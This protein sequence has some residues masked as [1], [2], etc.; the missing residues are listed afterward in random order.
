MN[1]RNASPI[2]RLRDFAIG[3]TIQL[4]DDKRSLVISEMLADGYYHLTNR[5]YLSVTAHGC[6]E[7]MK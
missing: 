5:G 3:D 2:P 7:I 6:Q 1:N 4:P